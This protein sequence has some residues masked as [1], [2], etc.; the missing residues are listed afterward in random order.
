M[1]FSCTCL[2]SV[3]AY[4]PQSFA[5]PLTITV[6]FALVQKSIELNFGQ[7]NGFI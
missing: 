1:E 4:L 7:K 6:Y 2:Q 5:D 3:G